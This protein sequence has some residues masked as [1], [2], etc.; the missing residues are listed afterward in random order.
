[1]L[2]MVDPDVAPIDDPGE[3]PLV[4][5]APLVGDELGVAAA[6]VLVKRRV[7]ET[8]PLLMDETCEVETDPLD[9][10]VAKHAVGVADVIEI[11]LDHDPRA[12]VHLAEL[13]VGEA[14]RVEL[15]LR[16]VLDKAW[17]VELHPGCALLGQLLDHLA[18]DLDQGLDQIDGVE[19]LDALRQLGEQEEAHRS[20]QHRDRVDPELLHGL[21]VLVE[22]LRARQRERV[23]GPSSGTM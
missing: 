12:L 10:Q 18:V 19:V 7:A 4:A 15:L 16:A 6:A 9:R 1:M 23:S 14:E 3:E 5:E 2:E 17:L 11:G 13:L 21:G 20:D 8:D 22:R